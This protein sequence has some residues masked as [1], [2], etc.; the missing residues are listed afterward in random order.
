MGAL[1]YNDKSPLENMH[2]AKLYTIMSNP[3]T[4][5]FSMLS[6]EQYT[7]SR[8]HCIETILHTDMMVHQS[9]V[10]D[11]QMLYQ[12]NAEVFT[13]GDGSGGNNVAEIEIFSQADTKML[14]MEMFLHSADVSNPCRQW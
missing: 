5:A 11:L 10:K 4:N 7:E 12:M 8:K 3:L 14:V 2:C 9:M 6:K 1:Q 13:A